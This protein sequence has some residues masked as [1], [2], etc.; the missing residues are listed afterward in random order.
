MGDLPSYK[1]YLI[2][3]AICATASVLIMGVSLFLI[4]GRGGF[5]SD[6]AVMYLAGAAFAPAIMGMGIALALARSRS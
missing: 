2:L 5:I 6:R 1:P 4:L 3:A